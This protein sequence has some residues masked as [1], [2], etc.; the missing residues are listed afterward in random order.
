MIF[1]MTKKNLG[2][3]LL[4]LAMLFSFLVAVPVAA[5]AA[6]VKPTKITLNVRNKALRTGEKLQLTVKKVE[7]AKATKNVK[8][9]TSDKKAATVNKKGW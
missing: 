9:T 3:V 1:I 4:S 8:W 2:A 6:T 5:E 7:P